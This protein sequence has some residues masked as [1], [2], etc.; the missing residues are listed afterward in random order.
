MSTTPRVAIPDGAVRPDGVVPM[1]DVIAAHAPALAEARRRYFDTLRPL[2]DTD[3][4][5]HE[6]LRLA[7]AELTGCRLCRNQRSAA[8][9]EAGVDEGV[10]ERTRLG[11][12][13]GLD[14]R[15]R[16]ALHLGERIRAHPGDL[17]TGPGPAPEIDA[18]A[19]AAGTAMV[20]TTTRALA[21]GK[22]LV[23]LGLEPES[24]PVQE[25]A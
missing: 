25:P 11:R 4:V 10:I 19:V 23:A 21:D 22:A 9:A 3:P 13:D 5:A 14:E 2:M 18:L 8:A 6:L 7:T 12:Y 24:Y 16:T 1:A 17:A 20:M 15:S